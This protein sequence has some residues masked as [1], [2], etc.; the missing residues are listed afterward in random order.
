MDHRPKRN[1]G[2]Q[3]GKPSKKFKPNEIDNKKLK[4]PI[5]IKEEP[6]EDQKP[7]QIKEEPVQDPTS[8]QIKE[9]SPIAPIAPIVSLNEIDQILQTVTEEEKKIQDVFDT[10]K[11]S[12]S[13]ILIGPT[14]EVTMKMTDLLY[15]DY[16]S[17]FKNDT[18]TI[19]TFYTRAMRS[20]LLGKTN[21]PMTRKVYNGIQNI[22]NHKSTTLKYVLIIERNEEVQTSKDI[23]T[24]K[25]ARYF[26]VEMFFNKLL[27]ICQQL[28]NFSQTLIDDFNRNCQKSG[29]FGK[30]EKVDPK[31]LHEFNFYLTKLLQLNTRSIKVENK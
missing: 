13:I 15:S 12:D 3:T 28:Y 17:F 16:I 6:I 26:H 11:P 22:I 31:L 27:S 8:I 9:E 2:S 5:Q 20:E 25:N 29:I 24:I 21:V 4:K 19:L 1:G 7:I 18:R 23:L 10:L 30:D 14:G